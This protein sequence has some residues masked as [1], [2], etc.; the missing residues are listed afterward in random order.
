MLQRH[1]CTGPFLMQG[2]S[3]RWLRQAVR[4][5]ADSLKSHIGRE[6]CG[7][8]ASVSEELGCSLAISTGLGLMLGGCARLV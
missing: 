3:A 2:S 5:V 8:R 6:V 4:V 1:P 7:H